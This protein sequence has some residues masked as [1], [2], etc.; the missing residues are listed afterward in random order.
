M[1]LKQFFNTFSSINNAHVF[2]QQMELI[3]IQKICS[4]C[5]KPMKFDCL[6]E[7]F[8]CNSSV[9]DKRCNKKESLYTNT[10]FDRTKLDI[11]D[12]L[13]IIYC[14]SRSFTNSQTSIEV[15]CSEST[16]SFWF[17]KLRTIANMHMASFEAVQIGENDAIVEIDECMIVR[18]KYNTGRILVG[19]QQWIFGGIVRGTNEVFIEFV[20]DRKRDT[21]FE[22]LRRRVKNNSLIISDSWRGYLNMETLLNDKNFTHLQ[23]NHS[24]NFVNPDNGAHTQS[25]EGLWSVMKR[26]LRKHGTNRG[27][28]ESTFEKIQEDLYKKKFENDLFNQIFIDMKQFQ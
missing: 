19:Q 12:V 4:K 9:D 28:T 2:L 22:V 20:P 5:L 25:I 16:V 6:K 18:R 23:V 13:L 24:E 10:I 17:S 27:N 26:K 14:W 21:L 1:I 3:P 8:R 11:R 7:E 15:E